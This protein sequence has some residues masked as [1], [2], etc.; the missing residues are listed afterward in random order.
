MNK[1]SHTFNE[2]MNQTGTLES[3]YE[4]VLKNTFDL[5]FLN[6]PYDEIIFFG[7]GTD[8]NLCQSASFFTRSLLNNCSSNALPSSE[9]LINPGTYLKEKKKY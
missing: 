1:K 5:S 4:D 3:V 8:Y 7:C 9:L 2:I 6:K